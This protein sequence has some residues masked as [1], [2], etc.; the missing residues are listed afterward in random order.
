MISKKH[1]IYKYANIKDNSSF[2]AVSMSPSDSREL[3]DE[4]YFLLNDYKIKLS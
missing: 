4:F 1:K 2:R 3:L